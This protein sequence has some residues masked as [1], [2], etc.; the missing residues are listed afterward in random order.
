MPKGTRSFAV[1][2]HHIP[3]PGDVH[4]YWL[5]YG[6]AP[7]VDHLDE[8]SSAVGLLGTNSVNGRNEYTPPCSKG[9]GAKAYTITVY[10]LSARPTF[11]SGIAVSRQVLLDAV[12]TTTLGS[13]SLTVTYSRTG[14]GE[15]S[16]SP[17]VP[18]APR[19]K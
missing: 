8:A 1:V 5:V 6:L 19:G 2:M 3:G 15:T 12:S 11:P 7:T 9:P 18:P 4:G 14:D 17:G 16:A 13:A 10:A